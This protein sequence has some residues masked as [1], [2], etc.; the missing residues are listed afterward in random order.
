MAYQ[1]YKTIAVMLSIWLMLWALYSLVRYIMQIHP[2]KTDIITIPTWLKCYGLPTSSISKYDD[3][4]NTNIDGFSLIHI[5]IYFTI[6]LVIPDRYVAI[7]VASYLCEAYE[8]IAGWRSRWWQDPIV[9]LLGYWMGSMVHHT[10][11]L[12]TKNI[13]KLCNTAFSPVITVAVLL[14]VFHSPRFIPFAD[15]SGK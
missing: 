13:I 8:W 2:L 5:V 1:E 7:L 15:S 10:Y 6:G 14:L 4:N 9:N 12:D 11:K 3:C